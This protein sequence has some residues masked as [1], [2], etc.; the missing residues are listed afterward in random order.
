MSESAA[1]AAAPA[2]P[3]AETKAPAA[4]PAEGKQETTPE[5]LIDLELEDGKPPVKVPV[6]KIPLE[7]LDP[8][9]K[10]YRSETDRLRS[11]YDKKEKEVSARSAKLE[12]VLR[13]AKEDTDGT[14]RELGIDPDKYAE[15]KIAARVQAAMREADEAADPSKKAARERD[16]ELESLRKKVADSEKAQKEQSREQMLGRVQSAVNAIVQKLPEKLRD[17]SIPAV[18]GILRQAVA[19]G[20]DISIDDAAKAAMSVIRARARALYDGDEE[21]R[22]SLGVAP[23]KAAEAP[24]AATK[25]VHPAANGTPQRD[26]KGK[27]LKPDPTK[28][29][30][31]ILQD[32]QRGR[33]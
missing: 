14:L 13:A 15:S 6:K 31:D 12:A 26:E 17:G 4:P 16:E 3:A 21:W 32:I 27:F 29:A 5:E 7:K 28:S 8:H 10:K 22:K 25:P 9:L 24:K 20:K 11:E 33:F 18:V 19:A 1:P 30:G 2:A 23:A